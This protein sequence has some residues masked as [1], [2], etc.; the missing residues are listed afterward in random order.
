MAQRIIRDPGLLD[1]LAAC[2]AQAGDFQLW[3]IVRSGRDPLMPSGPGGRWDD[4]SFDVLYTANAAD[5]A[6]AEVHYHLSRLQP[7]FPSQAKFHLHEIHAAL[8]KALVFTSLDALQP[9]GIDPHGFGAAAYARRNAE[10]AASQKL[11]EAAHF[12]GFDALVVPSARWPASNTVLLMGHLA[13]DQVRH[14]RDHG[15]VDLAAWGKAN[16][17]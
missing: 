5:G 15:A 9:F 8:R 10:Y 17:R 4:G 12:L 11:A 16:S 7:V 6:K 3:R 13:E 2:E 1:R 14:V